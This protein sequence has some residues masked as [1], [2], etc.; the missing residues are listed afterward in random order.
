M[1]SRGRSLLLVD[2]RE[3]GGKKEEWDTTPCKHCPR[4]LKV[5]RQPY[6]HQHTEDCAIEGCD[7]EQYFCW[8]CDGML[9]RFCG[10]KMHKTGVCEPYRKQMEKVLT[11]HYRDRM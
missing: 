9:C 4:F 11:N 2:N 6:T 3:S 1:A 5:Y 7:H 10:R 8:R